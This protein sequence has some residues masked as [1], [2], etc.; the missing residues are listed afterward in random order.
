MANN[1]LDVVWILLC[2]VLVIMMQPGFVFLETGLTRTKNSISVAIKNLADFCIV[3]TIFGILGFGLM[4]GESINGFVGST[5]FLFE[6]GPNSFDHAYMLFQLSFCATAVTIISGAVAERIRFTGYLIVAFI[7]ASF[8]YPIVGHWIW[9]GHDHSVS[10]GWL[11]ALGFIDFAGASVVHVVGGSAAL[12][13]IIVIGP[14]LGRFDENQTGSFQ[15]ENLTYATAG[16]FLLIMGWFGFIGGSLLASDALLPVVFLNTIVA[17]A[18]GGAA[19]T[20]LSWF[21]EPQPNIIHIM[22]GI[23]AGLVAITGSCSTVSTLNAAIIG[24]VAGGLSLLGTFIL[25]KLKIDDAVGAVPVHLFP[26]VWGTLAV[27]LF[28]NSDSF[29]QGYSRWDQLFVQLTGAIVTVAYSFGVMLLLLRLVDRFVPLRVSADIERIGLNAG[30]HGATSEVYI[31]AEK[32]RTQSCENN[33]TNRV[34]INP[35]SDIGALQ[36][37]YNRVLDAV[38]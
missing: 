27:S 8:I 26:G 38:Q 18:F 36:L 22:V 19:T 5:Q 14:R 35:H 12:A 28:S 33:F 16:T 24:V 21:R 11:E 3:G 7:T 31:L 2:T 34:D 17:A 32:M 4:Y 13:A 30:E 6:A 29:I 9:A 10:K 15:G 20:A 1:P 23:L 25:E 37:E